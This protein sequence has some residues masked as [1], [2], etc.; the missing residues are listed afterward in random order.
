MTSRGGVNSRAFVSD[1]VAQ[2]V[3][4]YLRTLKDVT[5]R[6]EACDATSV[7]ATNT[8]LGSIKEP[9]AGCILLAAA[10]ADKP[11]FSQTAETFEVPFSKE[12]AF[13]V[14]EETLIIDDLDFCIVISTGSTFGNPGQSNYAA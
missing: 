14:L 9:I 12:R 13:R 4:G 1:N 8:L 7:S 11:F 10:I 5:L 2:R 3:Y 6:L